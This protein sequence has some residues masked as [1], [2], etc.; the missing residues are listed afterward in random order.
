MIAGIV[1]SAL[2]T[3]LVSL[4]T[5]RWRINLQRHKFDRAAEL[6]DTAYL[7]GGTAA[8]GDMTKA[9]DVLLS[10]TTPEPQDQRSWRL[11]GQSRQQDQSSKDPQDPPRSGTN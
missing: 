6:I 9:V 7:W 4:I 1:V 5:L 8:L 11:P 3:A 2:L 10:R